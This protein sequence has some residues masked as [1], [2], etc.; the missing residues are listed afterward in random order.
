MYLYVLS[1]LTGLLSL[2]YVP[3]ATLL[4]GVGVNYRVGGVSHAK[5]AFSGRGVGFHFFRQQDGLVLRGA[6]SYAISCR[7]SALLWDL[8]SSSVRAREYV[9]FRHASSY[10]YL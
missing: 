10:H 8:S 9:R 1:S 7:L 6:S 2:V 4:R 3:H 5:G